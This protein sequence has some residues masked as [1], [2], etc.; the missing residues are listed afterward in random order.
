MAKRKRLYRVFGKKKSETFGKFYTFMS[1][2]KNG[3]AQQARKKYKL[4]VLN[5]SKI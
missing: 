2:S 1:T 3:A 5:V 4:K